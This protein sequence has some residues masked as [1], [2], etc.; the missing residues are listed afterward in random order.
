MDIQM[1]FNVKAMKKLLYINDY[2]VGD[3]YIDLCNKH[4]YPSQH[5]W[6]VDKLCNE[7]SVRYAY[8]KK[9]KP[10]PRLKLFLNNLFFFL[11]NSDVDVVYSALP[12]YSLFFLLAKKLCLKN[13][14]IVTIVHHPSS[15]ILF[16]KLYNKM[17]F[18]SPYAFNKYQSYANSEYLFWGGDCDFYKKHILKCNKNISFISAGKVHRDYILLEKVMQEL[19]VSY[20]IFGNKDSQKNEITYSDLMDYYNKCRFVV[21]PVINHLNQRNA[22]VLCGLTSFV[23]AVMLGIPILMSDN[24][25]IGVNIEKEGMGYVYRAGDEQDLKDKTNKLLALSNYEYL[26][27]KQACLRFAYNNSYGKFCDRLLQILREM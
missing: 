7:Y 19:G 22:Q 27:M 23:D 16:P 20:K 4:E 21:I 17:I 8:A 24:T 9:S 18:I 5:L 11:K 6:G 12:G 14:R 10:F 1:N 15:H 2:A 25:L 3:F 13:Y 26:Q